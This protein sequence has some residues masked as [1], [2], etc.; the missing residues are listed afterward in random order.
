[1]EREVFDEF[2]QDCEAAI[3][4]FRRELAKL[5]TGRANI[6]ILDHVRVDYY[7]TPTPLNQLATLGA[8]EPRLLTIKPWDK[9][10]HDAIVKAIG[11]S[12]LGIT[13]NSD[14]EIIRLPIPP[15]TEERRHEM[16]KQVKRQLEEG[17][18]SMRN[19]RRVANDLLKEL[20]EDKSI[21]ED[22]L[23]RLMD[24]V[25]KLTDEFAAKGDGIAAKKEK[26]LLEV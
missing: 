10:A 22:D 25:Q 21:T 6:S 12:D 11:Q 15:L 24:N 14:G 9:S 2:K 26:E 3:E 23:H 5:R 1:M 8:P 4:A 20:K 16:V 7:G 17:K 13:P 19:A 18:V